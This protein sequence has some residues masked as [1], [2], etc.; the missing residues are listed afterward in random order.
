MDNKWVLCEDR[1][2]AAA[3]GTLGV[4]MKTKVQVRAEN[5]KEY[6]TVYLDTVSQVNP[7]IKTAELMRMVKDGSLQKVDPEHPLLYALEGIKSYLALGHHINNAERVI[8]VTRKGT[9]RCAY[10]RE[11][12]SKKQIESADRFLRGGNP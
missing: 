2:L 6:I 7:A 9:N 12:A 3:F 10:I 11:S 8:L 4:V 1:A 5:G